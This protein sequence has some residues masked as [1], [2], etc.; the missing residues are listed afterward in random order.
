MVRAAVTIHFKLTAGKPQDY[1]QYYTSRLHTSEVL[2][3]KDVTHTI[4][5]E[6]VNVWEGGDA[7]WAK[8][9]ARWT[10]DASLFPA[11]V[12]FT[13]PYNTA[14]AEEFQFVYRGVVEQPEKAQVLEETTPDYKLSTREDGKV[15]VEYELEIVYSIGS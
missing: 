10:C 4:Q 14:M 8:D 3:N 2:E 15:L 9:S 12:D 11:A 7:S 13:W 6:R 1:W 5:M